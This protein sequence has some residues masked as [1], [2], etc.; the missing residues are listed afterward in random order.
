MILFRPTIRSLAAFL[1][2]AGVFAETS[3]AAPPVMVLSPGKPLA[4]DFSRSPNGGVPAG[5][6]NNFGFVLDL[7]RPAQKLAVR[8]GQPGAT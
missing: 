6:F 4:F 8:S 7:N 2:S 3:G 1:I 5:A